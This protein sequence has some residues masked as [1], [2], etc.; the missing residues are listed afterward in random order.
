MK[1]KYFVTVSDVI[2][3]DIDCYGIPRN[4]SFPSE[5]EFDNYDDAVK[6]A[7]KEA[8]RKKEDVA[9]YKIAS[10]ATFPVDNIT[11]EEVV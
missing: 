3:R 9:I 7:K 4:K 11:I 10:V 6:A 2:Y 5:K 8:S 1:Q